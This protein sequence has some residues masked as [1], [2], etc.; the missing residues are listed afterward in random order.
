VGPNGQSFAL[1]ELAGLTREGASQQ[2]AHLSYGAHVRTSPSTETR[3]I[4]IV[5][6]RGQDVSAPSI[7]LRGQMIGSL[8]QGWALC[9]RI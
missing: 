8:V 3:Q 5:D 6:R 2:E 1:K 7:R 9:W 4:E